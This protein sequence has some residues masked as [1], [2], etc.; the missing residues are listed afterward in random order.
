MSIKNILIMSYVIVTILFL[1]S[2]FFKL[3]I[4][5]Q[6]KFQLRFPFSRNYFKKCYIALP[7]PLRNVEFPTPH[8]LNFQRFTFSLNQ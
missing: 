1:L 5:N 8:T 6:Q 2:T 7:S 3:C 4:P